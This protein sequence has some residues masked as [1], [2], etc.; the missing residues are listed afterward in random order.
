MANENV[1]RLQIEFNEKYRKELKDELNLKNIMQVPVLKKIVLNVGAG[2]A[3]ANPKVMDSILTELATITGQQPVRTRARKSI[4]TFK[5]RDGMVIGAKVTLRGKR[6]Y[7]FF[8][9]LV[10]VALPRVRDFN[11]L[12]HKSFD[13]AGNYSFGIKEQIIFPEIDFDK[14]ENIHGFDVTLVIQSQAQEHSLALLRKFNFPIRQ[15]REN[16]K[17]AG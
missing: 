8:D 1:A 4:A 15:K 7:E 17:E 5:L 11:G 9:R 10:N 3:V 14:V 12:S 6:M 13:H 2:H 16:I